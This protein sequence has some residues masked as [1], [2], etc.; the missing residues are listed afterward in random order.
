VAG[1]IVEGGGCAAVNCFFYKDIS[2]CAAGCKLKKMHH[3]ETPPS[4]MYD[5]AS[6]WG[7]WERQGVA[8]S[9]CLDGGRA[10]KLIVASSK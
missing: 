4:K 6:R 8:K 9:P 5:M 3:Q 2:C 7:H 10:M 1:D